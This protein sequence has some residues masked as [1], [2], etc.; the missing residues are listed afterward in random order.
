MA[1]TYFIR[2]KLYPGS[3]S[4]S[5]DPRTTDDKILMEIEVFE[6]EDEVRKTL[7]ATGAIEINEMNHE[8]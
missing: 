1:I 8:K 2:N 4:K 6:N 7:L 5:P 3:T